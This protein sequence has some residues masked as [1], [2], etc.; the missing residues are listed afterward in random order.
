MR[1]QMR[2]QNVNGVD[3]TL[4]I[5]ST[6]NRMSESLVLF[7]S[8]INSRWFLQTSIILFMN[9]T[10]LFKAKWQKVGS[11]FFTGFLPCHD[12]SIQKS[13]AKRSAK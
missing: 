9:K 10:D 12:M 8:V 13:N 5:V 2:R 4:T 6:Q 1:A 11:H 7:E 3:M